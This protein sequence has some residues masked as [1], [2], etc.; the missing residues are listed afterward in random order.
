MMQ[1]A[2]IV[3]GHWSAGGGLN[4]EFVSDFVFRPALARRIL[5]SFVL[6]KL[7]KSASQN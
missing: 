5:F 2:I 4:L 7:R 1:Q 3:F 6:V